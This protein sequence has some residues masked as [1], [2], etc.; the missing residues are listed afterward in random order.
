MGGK[1]GD[2]KNPF[3]SRPSHLIKEL[4]PIIQGG[5]GGKA[6]AAQAGGK[7]PQH[8]QKALTKVEELL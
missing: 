6:D 1:R 7:A 8:L 3:P 5:G 4:S 2:R